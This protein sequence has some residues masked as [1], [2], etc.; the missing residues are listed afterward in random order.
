MGLAIQGRQLSNSNFQ[1]DVL[2]G[3]R[4]IAVFIV[5]LSHNS[6]AGFQMFPLVN[7][8][9][10]GHEGVFLFF[11]LSSF[12]LTY[13]FIER[14]ASGF[15]IERL[16]NYFERRFFRIYPLYILYLTGGLISTFVLSFL[17]SDKVVGIPFSLTPKE[18]L[19]HLLMAYGK[20]VAWSIPIE[21]KYYFL[22]PGIAYI[23]VVLLKKNLKLSGV[24]VL[25]LIALVN[26]IW[27]LERIIS[28]RS[29]VYHLPIFLIGALLAL[30]HHKWV[31]SDRLKSPRTSLYVETLGILSLLTI[32]LMTPSILKSL[33]LYS[34]DLPPHRQFILFSLLWSGVIFA[35]I[36]GN[37]LIGKIFKLYPLRYLGYISF[38]AYLFHPIFIKAFV[39]SPLGNMLGPFLSGWGI[40]LLTIILSWI[41]FTLIE[42]PT[43]RLSLVGWIKGRR[44]ATPLS[45]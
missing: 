29:L 41:S 42:K 7:F 1:L 35:A 31:A 22:L 3:L 25:F 4:G 38:S 5:I 36:H 18:Y 40:L 6:L 33:G 15:S 19:D 30:L 20:G 24:F 44:I 37:G 12:L 16:T 34:V 21:F 2:D 26:I 23:I 8:Y 27:P 13:P 11:L 45:L 39:H 10:I 14:G 43:S 28:I 9:G 17:I 32:F